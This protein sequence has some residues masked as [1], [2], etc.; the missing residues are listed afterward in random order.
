M[1]RPTGCIHAEPRDC[2]MG[3][4]DGATSLWSRSLMAPIQAAGALFFNWP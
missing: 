1:L 2:G 4:M 3:K